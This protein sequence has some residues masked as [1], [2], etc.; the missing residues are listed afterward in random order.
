Q[1][2]RN[3]SG[4]TYISHFQVVQA[5]GAGNAIPGVDIGQVSFITGVTDD[6]GDDACF[7]GIF[8]AIGAN[9]GTAYSPGDVNLG[10]LGLQAGTA[11]SPI[12]SGIFWNLAFEFIGSVL[13]STLNTAGSDPGTLVPTP[14]L[15]HLVYEIQG[16]V[17]GGPSNRQ[18]WLGSTSELAGFNPSGSGTTGGVTNGNSQFGIN[19]YLTDAASSGTIQG[20]RVIIEEF[21][22]AAGFGPLNLLGGNNSEIECFG[23]VA[24]Q[25]PYLTG[26]HN[27]N[28][29]NGG[30][31]WVISGGNLSTIDVRVVDKFAGATNLSSGSGI[32]N[33]AVIFNSAFLLWCATP[34]AT[35]LQSPLSWDDFGGAIPPQL[36]S[37]ILGSLPVLRA[38]GPQRVCVNFDGTTNAFLN[39]GF[40]LQTSFSDALDPS[41]DPPGAPGPGLADY[42]TVQN[43]TPTSGTA[44]FA[45]GPVPLANPNPTAAGLRFGIHAIGIQAVGPSIVF[46]ELTNARTVVLQ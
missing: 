34:P 32:A 38:P 15:T 40:S 16:P 17:N 37:F 29:G 23:A 19:Q 43:P 1:G 5:W 4:Q 6:L 28:A 44:S 35:M 12:Q 14:L 24:F 10:A 2:G 36:G 18:Y 46:T 8:D 25:T 9:Q 31:D 3:Q 41:D 30:A 20:N 42:L 33:P 11:G 39:L 13:P 7:A 27:G 26:V 21:G 45:S 22:A